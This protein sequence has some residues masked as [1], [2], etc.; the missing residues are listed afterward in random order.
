MRSYRMELLLTA[1]ARGWAAGGRLRFRVDLRCGAP[2]C[3]EAGLPMSCRECPARTFPGASHAFSN[4]TLNGVA[5][6]QSANT[7]C[8][9]PGA[10][11]NDPF[12]PERYVAWGVP[13]AAVRHGVNVLRLQ[14]ARALIKGVDACI[15]CGSAYPVHFIK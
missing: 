15:A 9:W 11:A 3:G 10:A 7:S 4:V 14:V 13:A 5:L 12:A 8:L 6:A 2:S 1:P